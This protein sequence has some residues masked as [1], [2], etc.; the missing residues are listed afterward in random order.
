MTVR[1]IA[2]IEKLLSKIFP[3]IIVKTTRV[4]VSLISYK[5]HIWFHNVH[6]WF[7][8]TIPVWNQRHHIRSLYDY[9]EIIY[10]PSTNTKNHTSIYWKSVIIY[11]FG[12]YSV[13]HHL[14]DSPAS[15]C[16]PPR[17]AKTLQYNINCNLGTK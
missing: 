15:H 6:T 3:V 1:I 7:L 2:K 17:S 12:F 4:E 5:D 8:S 13:G 10:D 16:D 11:V 9:Q 14:Y